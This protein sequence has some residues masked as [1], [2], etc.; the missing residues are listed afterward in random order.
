MSFSFPQAVLYFSPQASGD[1]AWSNG[2]HSAISGTWNADQTSVFAI[3]SGPAAGHHLLVAT[4]QGHDN[5]H[6]TSA[7]LA[8]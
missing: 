1:I 5:Y 7:I 8:P 4:T 3:T 6:V 2:S